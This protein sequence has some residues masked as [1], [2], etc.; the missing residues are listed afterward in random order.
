M[1]TK[2]SLNEETLPRAQLAQLHWPQSASYESQSWRQ[3]HKLQNY[4]FHLSYQLV[5]Q[6]G[7]MSSTPGASATT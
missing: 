7:T 3:D 5:N 6:V 1:G 2:K 4:Q